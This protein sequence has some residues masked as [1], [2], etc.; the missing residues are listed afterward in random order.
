MIFEDQ[1]LTERDAAADEDAGIRIAVGRGQM[2]DENQAASIG[3]EAIGLPPPDLL[4]PAG[5][6]ARQPLLS[7]ARL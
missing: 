7:A 6:G 4:L 3:V 5:A 1:T 2:G